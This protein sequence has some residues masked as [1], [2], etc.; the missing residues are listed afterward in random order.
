MGDRANKERQLQGIAES[1]KITT[2]SN[3]MRF[4]RFNL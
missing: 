3:G 4:E 1:V 2:A